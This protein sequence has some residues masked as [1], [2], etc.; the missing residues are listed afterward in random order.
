MAE[1]CAVWDVAVRRKLSSLTTPPALESDLRQAAANV[2]GI[3]APAIPQLRV[4]GQLRAGQL[5]AL[6]QILASGRVQTQFDTN[7]SGGA[8]AHNVR[9][10]LEAELFGYP[11]VLDPRR[12]PVY[13]YLTTLGYEP[14]AVEN[15]GHFALRLRPAI[16]R[17][18]TLSA[19]DTLDRAV[20]PAAYTN[21]PITALIPNK[22]G[23]V[24]ESLDRLLTARCIAGLE[25]CYVEAQYHGG[26][27]LA[28]IEAILT[29]DL[30]AVPADLREG[31]LRAGIEFREFEC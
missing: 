11:L 25:D 9:A 7:T 18:T 23:F 28:D 21:L 27:R 2:K 1:Q 15:Y 6:G 14:L 19:A 26:V 10:N 20:L 3:L 31:Y 22:S 30:A 5:Y 4:G 24:R 29:W 13:G 16:L 12:R 8:L 17:R